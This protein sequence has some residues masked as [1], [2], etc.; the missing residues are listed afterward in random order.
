MKTLRIKIL[1]ISAGF[2]IGAIVYFLFNPIRYSFF[3]ECPFYALTGF[4]C[5]GCGSQRA[6]H[7]LLHGRLL[8]A[9]G[10]NLL[11]MSALPFIIYSA[12][13]L[14][15]NTF[16]KKRW[17]QNLFY[18]PW[19]AKFVLIAVLLF[20]LLRNLPFAGMQWMAP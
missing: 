6:F 14:L 15:G 10:Y 16:F 12:V 2:L 4:Y 3:P 9:A 17:K 18:K 7:A 8:Q 1:V 11:T 20:G 5:P 19:F 13:V